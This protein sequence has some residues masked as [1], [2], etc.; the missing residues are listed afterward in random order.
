MR[1]GQLG[2][3]QHTELLIEP[4]PQILVGLQRRRLLAGGGQREHQP[5][6]G[7]LVQRLP[8]GQAREVTQH[9][10]RA[11]R[12]IGQVGIVQRRR[13]AGPAGL[14]RRRVAAQRVHVGGGLTAPQPERLLIGVAGGAGLT[15]RGRGAGMAG[16][17]TEAQQIELV[18]ADPQPVAGALRH[19]QSLRVPGRP[20]RIEGPAQP[21][22]VG[23]QQMYCAGWRLSC[24]SASISAS[25]CTATSGLS[26]SSASTA[27]AGAR[28][29]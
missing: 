24:Q 18:G 22:H 2:A 17:L 4:P 29:A 1:P 7:L 3:G 20:A 10:V 14:H 5:G 19:Q 25:R 26:A 27:A 9:L 21:A 11:A 12:L 28:R 23:L 8:G 6:T 13:R 16:Q 15:R